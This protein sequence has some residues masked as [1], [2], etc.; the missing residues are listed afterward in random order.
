MRLLHQVTSVQNT[1]S[2]VLSSDTFYLSATAKGR[3]KFEREL[4][5]SL[6][7]VGVSR[8]LEIGIAPFVCPSRIPVCSH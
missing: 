8:L 3:F 1:D 6:F 2:C 7:G 5:Y 4:F